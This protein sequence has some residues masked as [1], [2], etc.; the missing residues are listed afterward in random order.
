MIGDAFSYSGN[1]AKIVDV[2][3]SGVRDLEYI[4]NYVRS[5]S[6]SGTLGA[7]DFWNAIV[8][9]FSGKSPLCVIFIN[10]LASSLTAVF[11]YY[12][13]L[14]LYDK[15]A[16]RISALLTAFWPSLFIWSI[17]DLKEPLSIFLIVVLVWAIIQ[18]KTRFRLHLIF[19]MILASL[20]LKEL[21]FVSFFIFYALIF[22][23]SL[24]LF[25]WDKHKL[26]FIFIIILASV[27]AATCVY[28]YIMKFLPGG[29]NSFSLIEYIY[30]MRTF[31]T[32]GNTAFLS[33]LDIT[34]PLSLILFAPL[35]IFVAWLAPFPWQLGSMSQV[36][37]IPEMIVYY[38]LLPAMFIGWSFIM[39]HK[40][41]EGGIVV[42]YIAIMM[43][44]L[45]FIEGNIG[46]LFRHRAMV[47]PFVFV[48]IGIGLEK[49]SIEAAI[50]T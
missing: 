37:V 1:G 47:L 44:V 10:S 27:I 22:P 36:M 38:L 31:R 3:L 39:K 2:W 45:A 11:I 15:R 24:I 5:I 18:L 30:K 6:T 34:N 46:T 48:L 9:F 17:Q 26:L 50:R 25:L 13:T 28:E 32:Y 7:F 4:H 16:A 49:K 40:A 33:S 41:R 8:Y 43:L 23:V 20:A 14:Q 42:L 29:K 19:I 35:A 21:R 12:I